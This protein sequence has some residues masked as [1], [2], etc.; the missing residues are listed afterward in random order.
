MVWS[1]ATLLA[2]ACDTTWNVPEA[3]VTPR[4]APDQLEAWTLRVQTDIDTWADALA[5]LGCTTPPFVLS[6]VGSGYDV[7]LVPRA[8]WTDSDHVGFQ[9][10]DG[11]DIRSRTDGSPPTGGTLLH[12][13]GHAMG[14]DH[15]VGRA[16]V[17]NEIG[18]PRLMPGDAE[19][20]MAVLGCGV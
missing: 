4:S 14:L 2:T 10:A 3:P 11:I 18:A 1:A 17:M 5:E 15:V 7:T 9:H 8:D 20:A 19:A 13:L 12:E 16:S 6:P